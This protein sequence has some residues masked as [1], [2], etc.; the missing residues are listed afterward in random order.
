MAFIVMGAKIKEKITV[1][2][3]FNAKISPALRHA[4]TF[5]FL[6]LGICE[7]TFPVFRNGTPNF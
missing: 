3:C 7:K 6:N 1:W 5:A 2:F 4:S